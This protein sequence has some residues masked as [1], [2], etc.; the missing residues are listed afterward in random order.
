MAK[1][2]SSTSS[3][4]GKPFTPGMMA[5]NSAADSVDWPGLLKAKKGFPRACLCLSI[6]ENCNAASLQNVEAF[7][8]SPL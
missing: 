6:S 8:T 5:G 3:S 1:G 7:L 4:L 2:M